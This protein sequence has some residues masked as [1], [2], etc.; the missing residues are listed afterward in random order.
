[1]SQVNVSTACLRICEPGGTGLLQFL[2]GW[3]GYAVAT[4]W[5]DNRRKL[6]LPGCLFHRQNMKWTRQRVRSPAYS[7]M[8]AQWLY[9]ATCPTTL[10][11]AVIYILLL[12][13]MF[14]GVGTVADCFM[15]VWAPK[16]QDWFVVYFFSP[17]YLLSPCQRQ[18]VVLRAMVWL[19]HL[20]QLRA[21][22]AVDKIISKKRLWEGSLFQV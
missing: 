12:L 2:L 8:G 16:N 7:R 15:N 1:M 11:G 3:F 17:Q 9:G 19:S 13:Y 6:G 10:L 21:P 22:Q 14:M 18:L 4:C 5:V 20:F